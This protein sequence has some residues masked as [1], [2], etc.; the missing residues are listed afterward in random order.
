MKVKQC[1]P[2]L[3][4]H[5]M[6]IITL[7]SGNF[8]ILLTVLNTK[9]TVNKIWLYNNSE[10]TA[11]TT[12]TLILSKTYNFFYLSSSSVQSKMS[13]NSEFYAILIFLKFKTSSG[14]LKLVI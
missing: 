11:M 7:A 2:D 12:R 9:K 4:L 14:T 10:P 13:I 8:N 6:R 1:G 3:R 5:K